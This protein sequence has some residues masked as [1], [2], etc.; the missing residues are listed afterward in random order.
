MLLLVGCSKQD[1]GAGNAPDTNSAV[2]SQATGEAQALYQKSWG[3]FIAG[4]PEAMKKL[5]EETPGKGWEKLYQRDYAGAEEAF[6]DSSAVSGRVGLGRTHLLEAEF[7]QSAYALALEVEQLNLK[8]WQENASR[9][10]KTDFFEY[11][12]G[13]TALR[14][15][16]PAE[17]L[18]H[19]QAFLKSPAGKG[20]SAG[21]VA[22][23]LEGQ[24]LQ[25]TGDTA[26]AEKVWKDPA[27]ARDPAA[28]AMLIGVREEASS[29]VKP[30]KTF[31]SPDSD[32]GKR[33][34]LYAQVEGGALEAATRTAADLD[35]KAP[36]HQEEVT[37]A[38]G[39][40]TRRYYDPLVLRSLARLHARQTLAALKE[41]PG[42]AGLYRAR[43]ERVLGTPL[44]AVSGLPAQV[45][46]QTLPAFI[47]SEY[48]TPAD[49]AG[50]VA[51]LGG[52]PPGDGWV[53]KYLAALG[54][55]PQTSGDGRDTRQAV[56]VAQAYQ[57]A[58]RK[59]VA[60]AKSDEGKNTVLQLRVPDG[61]VDLAIRERAERYRQKSRLLEALFLL[62][63]T[64]DKENGKVSYLNDP[65]LFLDIARVYCSLGRY[66]EAM[67]YV[68]RLVESRPELWLVQET[69]GNLSVLDTVD[70]VGGGGREN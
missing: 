22:L 57:E 31:P 6:A 15:G 10:Q 30:P 51:W 24:A 70:K 20:S 12:S 37:L 13:M 63:H 18:P 35:V 17:A 36:D 50:G 7:Y 40:V 68:Y 53:G 49:M 16:A 39:A 25:A 9:L 14:R 28:A 61:D 43:A 1:P 38:D 62:E 58:A 33:N 34:L 11:V 60:A 19:L 64:Y 55:V 2:T 66:R 8:L 59:L 46:A 21:A 45:D 56:E 26:G 23:V 54:P 65:R 44:E 27:I 29:D 4:Q 48:V 67:N 52:T 47:F 41:L 69:L 32:Y 42:A 5:L 3:T